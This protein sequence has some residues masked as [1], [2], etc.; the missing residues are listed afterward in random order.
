[1][2][3]DCWFDS[4]PALYISGQV[5]TYEQRGGMPGTKDSRQI[6]FQETDIVSMVK[7]VTKYAKMIEKFEDIRYEFEKAIYIAKS[8]R[9]G[10]VLLDIPM[11]L[12]RVPCDLTK[13]KSFVPP[14]TM[15]Y[16]D[17]GA[18]LQ[19]K[20][21]KA[22]KILSK[23]RRPVLI[24]RRGNDSQ[25]DQGNTRVGKTDWVPDHDFLERGLIVLAG[26]IRS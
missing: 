8:G 26:S 2:G 7:P 23:A 24:S 13:M 10:P 16:R 4:I 5:N 21:A 17:T 14:T 25:R 3:V 18:K 9:P 1:M 12:Q 15:P 11:D 19:D 6:G 22:W 20:V